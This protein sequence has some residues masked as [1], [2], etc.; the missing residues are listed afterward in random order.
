MP[1]YEDG[2]L[3]SFF[4]KAYLPPGIKFSGKRGEGRIKISWRDREVTHIPGYSQ[5][6][7]PVIGLNMFIQIKDVPAALKN[8]MGYP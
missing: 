6:E 2:D 1:G 8:E 7:S 5:R 3:L 4:Q